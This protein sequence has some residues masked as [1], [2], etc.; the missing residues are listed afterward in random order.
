MFCHSHYMNFDIVVN[1]ALLWHKHTHEKRPHVYVYVNFHGRAVI[2]EQNGRKMVRMLR[3]DKLVGTSSDTE[4]N[5]CISRYYRHIFCKG[6]LLTRTLPTRR[7][8]REWP[9]WWACLLLLSVVVNSD[10]GRLRTHELKTFS[11]CVFCGQPATTCCVTVEN[12]NVVDNVN[13]CR[14]LLLILL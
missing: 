4:K 12:R 1:V 5:S 8:R 6:K 7:S 2:H 14:N 13:V 10:V 9:Q 11:W 3:T